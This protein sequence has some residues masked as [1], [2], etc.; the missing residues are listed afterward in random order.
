MAFLSPHQKLSF[1][2][3][4]YQF[5]PAPPPVDIIEWVC[6]DAQLNRVSLYP[7][8]ATLLKILFLQDSLFTSYDEWVIEKWIDGFKVPEVKEE[9]DSYQFVPSGSL[10]VGIQ[11]DIMDRI[12]I[13]KEEGRKWFREVIPVI[14]RRGGKGHI[15]GIAGSYVLWNYILHW[16]PPGFYGV[17]R[18][19]AIGMF[20]FAGKLEHAKANQWRDIT[21]IITGSPQLSRFISRDTGSRLSLYSMAD[22]KRLAGV[23]LPEK[24]TAT[25]EILPKESTLVSARGPALMSAFFD[26]MAHVTASTARAD[27]EAVYGSAVPALDQFGIDAFIYQGSSPWQMTGQFY[28]NY[29]QALSIDMETNLPIY[30][31]RLMVQLPSWDIYTDWDKAHRIPMVTGRT[32]TASFH[33]KIDEDSKLVA[34]TFDPIKF[35]IQVYDDKMRRLERANPETFKVERLAQWATVLDA[36]LNP[37]NVKR[38]FDQWDGRDIIPQ[39]H[40]IL[41]RSYFC[42]ADPSKSGDNFGISLAHL[43]G[44]DEV[45]HMHVVF[46]KVHAWLPSDYETHEVDYVAIE[47]EIFRDWVVP[48]MPEWLTFDQFSST[49]IIQS[50]RR[51]II[52]SGLPRRTQVWERTA[53]NKENWAVAETFKTSLNLGW[54]HLPS[55]ELLRLEML[56]LQDKGNRVDHP[57]SG[58][59]Q[60]KDVWDTVSIIVHA[61]LGSQV[62]VYR[63]QLSSILP[64]GS[65]PPGGFTPFAKGMQDGGDSIAEKFGSIG[66]KDDYGGGMGRG[67]RGGGR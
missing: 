35:P 12:R 56:F 15:G 13:N 34:K 32:N 19:K 28:T 9:G 40:G 57:S 60:S 23:R 29:Q 37:D 11:P 51:R 22:L 42:H 6:S 46:D 18:D 43:E 3:E 4:T 21:N 38:A 7:R 8:Q 50:L 54:I 66:R 25:F 58:P 48:F 41:S 5:V 26:E 62:E 65:G 30:P 59:V 52:N 49:Q 45:G 17:D 31:E 20:V 33:F 67:R 55:H 2:E 47:E 61:L 36:Y 1:L 24:D 53:T 39:T 44:P 14:G 27:A 63:D 64:Q 16:D 10:A